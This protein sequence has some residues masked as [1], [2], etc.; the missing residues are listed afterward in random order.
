MILRCTNEVFEK[1]S[2]FHIYNHVIEDYDLFYD[3]EDYEYFLYKF[4]VNQKKIASSV[5]AYC[6]MPNHYHF[7]I[8]QDSEEKIYKIFNYSFISY[9]KYFNNK[10]SRKGPIFRSPLQ[11]KFIDNGIHLLQLCKYIHMNPVR[12]DIVDLPEQWEYSDYSDWINEK[13]SKFLSL[14]VRKE[15]CPYPKQYQKFI[16]SYSNFLEQYEFRK[17]TFRRY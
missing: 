16:N 14:D 9:A 2:T 3:N 11:H 4:S 8:R 10:Y 12:K 1:N 5:F 15:I 6:L 13:E 17:L 7:L